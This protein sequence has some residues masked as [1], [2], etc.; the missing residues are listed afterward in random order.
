MIGYAASRKIHHAMPQQASKAI[1]RS[2]SMANH[3]Q[4]PI[5][6]QFKITE[7]YV[8][9]SPA[10]GRDY[11]N[12]ESAKADFLAGKDFQLESISYGGKYCSI[13]DFAKNVKVEVR[14]NKLQSAV[15][16]EVV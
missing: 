2:P 4:S 11:K 3:F 6:M 1:P 12:K 9:V 8:V 5:T 14:Y 15:I 13:R 7:D 16:V 10:Y